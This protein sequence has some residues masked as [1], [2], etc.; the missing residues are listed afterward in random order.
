MDKSRIKGAAQKL[1]GS[2]QK[3]VGKLTGNKAMENDGKIDKAKGAMNTQVGKTK[4]AL[5]G[6]S[7]AR[8]K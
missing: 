3:T 5:R 7:G 8:G 1:K 4:D 6:A 2:F